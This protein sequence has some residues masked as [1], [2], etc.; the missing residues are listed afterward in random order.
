MTK[1]IMFREMIT[2][3]MTNKT[4]FLPN[5]NEAQGAPALMPTGTDQLGCSKSTRLSLGA[6]M[7]DQAM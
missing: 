3:M 6:E 7:R 5:E 2:K 1:M 4:Y